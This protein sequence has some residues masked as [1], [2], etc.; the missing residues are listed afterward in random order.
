MAA[1]ETVELNRS[2]GAPEEPMDVE[3][4]KFDE[5]IWYKKY[6]LLKRKCSEYEQV[7]L[8]ETVRLCD[9]DDGNYA[10]FACIKRDF[11]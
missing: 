10:R 5:N 3:S 4:T 6:Q 1:A 7:D 9:I 2:P 11:Q 8:L